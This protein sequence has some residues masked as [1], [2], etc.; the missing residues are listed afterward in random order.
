[1]TLKSFDDDFMSVVLQL[2]RQGR[3]IHFTGEGGPIG[4]VVDEEE[5][6]RGLRALGYSEVDPSGC[7][8][9]QIYPR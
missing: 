6:I 8:E 2:H 4:L 1:M 7:E 3:S 5:V 9:W